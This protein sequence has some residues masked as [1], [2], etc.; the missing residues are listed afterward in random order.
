MTPTFGGEGGGKREGFLGEGMQG[1]SGKEDT[2]GSLRQKGRC[3][4]MC[5]GLLESIF[6]PGDLKSLD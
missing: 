1:D 6:Q 3:E 2:E 4:Q 5:A